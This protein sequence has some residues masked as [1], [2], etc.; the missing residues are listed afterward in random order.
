MYQERD[1][2]TIS[3]LYN[4]KIVNKTFEQKN[5]VLD[6]K[7]PQG[8]IEVIGGDITVSEGN[9]GEAAFFVKIPKENLKFANTPLIIEVFDGSELLEEI[10]TNFIGPNP[11]QKK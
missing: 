2:G 8:E 7:S 10:K 1:D 6:L 4:L 5:I 3:N 9:L 11:F